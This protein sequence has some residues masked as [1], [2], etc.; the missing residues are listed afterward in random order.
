MQ[1]TYVGAYSTNRD[2]NNDDIEAFSKF[3]K[4]RKLIG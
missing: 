2:W 4:F 3:Y 1:Y